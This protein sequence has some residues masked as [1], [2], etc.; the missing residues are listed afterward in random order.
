MRFRF[1]ESETDALEIQKF[2]KGSGAD[3]NSRLKI[4]ATFKHEGDLDALTI[5]N[6][7]LNWWTFAV[8]PGNC[9]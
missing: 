4:A 8:I 6:A 3:K 7:K 5:F 9:A 1:D 2:L